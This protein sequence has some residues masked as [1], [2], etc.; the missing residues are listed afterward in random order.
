MI[1]KLL[2]KISFPGQDFKGIRGM[3]LD[4][5]KVLCALGPKTKYFERIFFSFNKL[6]NI[7]LF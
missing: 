3:R 2:N 6:L 4:N 7:R 1:L 5:R